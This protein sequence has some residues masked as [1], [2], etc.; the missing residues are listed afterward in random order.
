MQFLRIHNLR[1]RGCCP[2]YARHCHTYARG[3]A[4]ADAVQ[5]PRQLGM[6][7]LHVAYRKLPSHHPNGF[8]CKIA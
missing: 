6:T 5:K 3:S 4:A 8:I 1:R 2:D 7:A